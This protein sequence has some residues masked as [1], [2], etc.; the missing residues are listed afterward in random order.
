MLNLS[1]VFKLKKI[2]T[3]F[4]LNTT[5]RKKFMDSSTQTPTK[6]FER[7]INNFL[8]NWSNKYIENKHNSFD[9]YLKKCNNNLQS[10]YNNFIINLIKSKEINKSTFGI[11]KN[12]KQRFKIINNKKINIDNFILRNNNNFLNKPNF[13]IFKSKLKNNFSYINDNKLYRKNTNIK[14]IEEYKNKNIFDNLNKQNFKFLNKN[15]YKNKIMQKIIN[16]INNE[17]KFK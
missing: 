4:K 2:S 12:F 5:F 10:E 15:L 7:N 9:N 17:K 16:N 3:N 13:N 1:P 8:T 6:L 11:L 14:E